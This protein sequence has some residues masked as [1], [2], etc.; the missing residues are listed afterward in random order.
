[1]HSALP[2]AIT[3]LL[4]VQLFFNCTQLSVITY[5]NNNNINNNN[6]NNLSITEDNVAKD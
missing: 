3:R 4:L 2:R 1:M 5:T 6:N